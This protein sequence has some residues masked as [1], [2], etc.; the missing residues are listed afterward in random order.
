MTGTLLLC[1]AVL[2]QQMLQRVNKN[3]NEQVPV[4]VVKENNKRS[5]F[6][7]LWV[8]PLSLLDGGVILG[9]EREG[10][11]GKEQSAKEGGGDN[12]RYGVCLCNGS[13]V[14]SIPQSETMM[15]L[16]LF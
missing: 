7:T 12:R 9:K 6:C 13:G 16:S 1:P 5:P 15:H 2:C 14:S 3:D 4:P 11:K 8:S 10:G